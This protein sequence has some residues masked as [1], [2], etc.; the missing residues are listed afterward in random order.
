MNTLVDKAALVTGGSRGIGAGIVHRLAREDA[1]VGF[2]YR[3]D[4]AG[5]VASKVTA[6][7]RRGVAIQADNADPGSVRAAVDRTAAELGGLDILVNS[8]G[9]LPFKPTSSSPGRSRPTP[10]RPTGRTATS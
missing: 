8:A 6:S 7:G 9:M 2:T 4:T 3:S 10:A 5:E 1:D